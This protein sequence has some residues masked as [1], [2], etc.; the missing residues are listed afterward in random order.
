M[1]L[2]FII[3]I[4]YNIIN[5]A[6]SYYRYREKSLSKGVIANLIF[7]FL[8]YINLL[9]NQIIGYESSTFSLGIAICWL[10]AYAIVYV[11]KKLAK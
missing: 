9:V 4:I 2:L 8:M 11:G 5:I 3:V 10:V 7:S 1:K 6:Y